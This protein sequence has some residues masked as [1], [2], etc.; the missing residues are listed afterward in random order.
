LIS[1]I[2]CFR[3]NTYF[4]VHVHVNVRPSMCPRLCP[5]PCA[6]SCSCLCLCLLR[7]NGHGHEHGRDVD[8]DSDTDRAIGMDMDILILPKTPF[9]RIVCRISDFCTSLTQ[10]VTECRA[11]LYS[12]HPKIRGSEIILSSISFITNIGQCPPMGKRDEEVS[13]GQVGIE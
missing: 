13:R 4:H 12:I 7:E 2:L 8:M 6:C 3:P 11:P 9:Q 1:D 10:S 5:C